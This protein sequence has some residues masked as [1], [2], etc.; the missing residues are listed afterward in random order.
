MKYR[1]RLYQ[2]VTEESSVIVEAGS[3]EEAKAFVIGRA[4]TCDIEWCFLEV[5][6]GPDIASVSE[7][8]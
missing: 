1:V 8:K 4:S 3:T 5:I 2:S 6:E 7:V